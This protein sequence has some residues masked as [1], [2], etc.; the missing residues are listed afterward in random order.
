MVPP[1]APSFRYGLGARCAMPP[2]RRSRPPARPLRLFRTTRE[3]ELKCVRRLAW[4]SGRLRRPRL[5]RRRPRARAGSSSCTS[6][7]RCNRRRPSVRGRRT[8]SRPGTSRPARSSS[9]SHC[10]PHSLD[11]EDIVTLEERAIRL[12]ALLL[13]ARAARGGTRR[14]RPACGSSG[15]SPARRSRSGRSGRR[16]AVRGR[17]RRRG[18]GLPRRRVELE[19]AREDVERVAVPLVEARLDAASRPILQLEQ[20]E[21]RPRS[22]D[23]ARPHEPALAGRPHDGLGR[24][25]A[26]VLRWIERVPVR[27]VE[28]HFVPARAARAP[29]THAPACAG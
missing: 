2:G 27:G 8:S 3:K 22:L 19:L 4:R 12:D 10:N 6:G 23:E 7:K 16:P 9:R 28:R 15:L 17:T 25:Q 13:R 11:V 24:G 29:R 14:T 5:P 1:P 20:R 26:A 18:R 21:L